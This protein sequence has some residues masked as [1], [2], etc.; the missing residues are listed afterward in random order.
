MLL[1]PNLP[2][3]FRLALGFLCAALSLTGQAAPTNVPLLLA[4]PENIVALWPAVTLLR[5]PEGAL[6]IGDVLGATDRF[7]APRSAYA[8]LGLRQKVVWLHVPVLLPRL[9]SLTQA[10]ASNARMNEAWVLDFDYT[11]LNRI[12][13][14]VT[15]DGRVLQHAVLG[16]SQPGHVAP[17]AQP[18]SRGGVVIAA[19]CETC[20]ADARRNVR[21][22]DPAD[23]AQ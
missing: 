10:A 9:D 4:N 20:A 23:D 16:N 2:T 8:T 5:D 12:D 21:Q 15:T 13:V 22:H 7:V 19:R 14:Y 6:K 17:T 1:L 3:A 18:L 11:L